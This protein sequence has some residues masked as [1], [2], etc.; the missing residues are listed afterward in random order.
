[1][2]TKDRAKQEANVI[3]TLFPNTLDQ[4]VI[5]DIKLAYD[6]ERLRKDYSS[7]NADKDSEGLLEMYAV[8]EGQL[9]ERIVA[10]CNVYPKIAERYIHR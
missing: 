6:I 5:T 8:V 3:N 9:I 1:M 2:N 10:H 4:I 7:W